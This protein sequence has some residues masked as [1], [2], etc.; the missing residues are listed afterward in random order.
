MISNP[1]LH[2][3]GRQEAAYK[4]EY[5]NVEGKINNESAKSYLETERDDWD[6]DR[7]TDL[8][9]D[10]D[11]LRRERFPTGEALHIAQHVKVVSLHIYGKERH[12]RFTSINQKRPSVLVNRAAT[13]TPAA[14][15]T[16]AGAPR[17]AS[18]PI[19]LIHLKFTCEY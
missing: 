4:Q 19:I 8:E 17:I 3:I 10:L 13:A 16:S 6:V 7:P 9:R 5:Y 12:T 2:Y 11:K 18:P 15:G 1:P 14:A